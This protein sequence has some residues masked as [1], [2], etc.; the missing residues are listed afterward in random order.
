MPL[1]TTNRL[2]NT[3]RYARLR[4]IHKRCCEPDLAR[5][6][7]DRWIADRAVSWADL[8]P[9]LL[10]AR[11]GDADALDIVMASTTKLA[12]EVTAR[13]IRRWKNGSYRVD[14]TVDDMLGAAYTGLTRAV[15][16]W[17]P[18]LGAWSTY[19]THWIRQAVIRELDR[20]WTV[21]LPVNLC[22][23]GDGM[24]AAAARDLRSRRVLSLDRPLTSAHDTG[25]AFS[26]QLPGLTPDHAPEARSAQAVEGLLSGL[27][28]R[29]RSLLEMRYG[30]GRP[31]LSIHE[32]ARVLKTSPGRIRK[33][34]ARILAALGADDEALS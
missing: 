7:R 25:R 24:A 32:A 29:D 28:H 30:I 11:E 10:R 15:E 3:P 2:S 13:E 12:L 22:L 5:L 18:V 33:R 9:H 19:A 34:E 23:K 1:H 27:A 20:W 8:T 26:D 4:G 21:M 16:L 17:R 31:P 14:P 6:D